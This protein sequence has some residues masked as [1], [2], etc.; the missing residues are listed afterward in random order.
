MFDISPSTRLLPFITEVVATMYSL[1]ESSF[2]DKNL[3]AD[4][5]AK[6]HPPMKTTSV[7]L[8]L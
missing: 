4:I 5:S 8:D 7:F 1:V 6:V 3:K 2:W